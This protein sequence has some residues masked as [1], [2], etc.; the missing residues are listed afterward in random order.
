[1]IFAWERSVNI[2]VIVIKMAAKELSLEGSK[3]HGQTVLTEPRGSTFL[4]CNPGE[5]ICRRCGWISTP[6]QGHGSECEYLGRSGTGL[7]GTGRDG[8]GRM[9]RAVPALLSPRSRGGE[10]DRAGWG[11]ARTQMSP[12]GSLPVPQL[13]CDSGRCPGTRPSKIAE[14]FS[15]LKSTSPPPPHTH[16]PLPSSPQGLD[17]ALGN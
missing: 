1:M 14:I 11:G 9:G 16:T 8:T 13:R 10:G 15:H 2:R 12:P 7:G 17:L 6:L 4:P 3:C 5:P